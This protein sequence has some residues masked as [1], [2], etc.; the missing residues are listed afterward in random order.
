VFFSILFY[1]TW[2]AAL[3][4]QPESVQISLALG[5]APAKKDR[6]RNTVCGLCIADVSYS[7]PQAVSYQGFS[8]DEL[9]P[10]LKTLHLMMMHPLSVQVRH[11]RI[12][13]R[14]NLDRVQS[15]KIKG[16]FRPLKSLQR[17]CWY[18]YRYQ[19]N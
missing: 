6:L 13:S 19:I 16:K 18:R 3:A 17:Q 12:Q 10:D 7:P 5:P 15:R 4:D 2:S 9:L 14:R 1:Y 8:V 11:S